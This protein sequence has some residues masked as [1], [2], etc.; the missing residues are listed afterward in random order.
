MNRAEW[1]AAEEIRTVADAVSYL[2]NFM[3]V[4]VVPWRKQEAL[5]R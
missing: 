3:P 4:F 2:S 5:K 1:I